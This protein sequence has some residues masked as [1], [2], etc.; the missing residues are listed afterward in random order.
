MRNTKE[1]TKQVSVTFNKAESIAGDSKMLYIIMNNS[2][3]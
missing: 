1:L 2:V 3:P